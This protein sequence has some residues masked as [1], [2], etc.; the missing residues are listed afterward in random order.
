MEG[1]R[2]SWN[3]AK[4]RHSAFRTGVQSG[5]AQGLCLHLNPRTG[6]TYFEGGGQPEVREVLRQH[7]R[8]DDFLR[9]RG[10]LDYF[11]CLRRASWRKS[12]TWWRSRPIREWLRVYASTGDGIR[13]EHMQTHAPP[14]FPRCD[15][16]G[17]EVKVFRRAQRLLKEKRPGIICGIDSEEKQ[18]DGLERLL[19]F[20]YTWQP[21]GTNHLLARPQ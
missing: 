15:V 2:T 20:A 10:T 9:Y 12:S 5:P 14:N 6:K 21:C 16:Q 17:V 19:P 13:D 7:L 1:K 4:T 11:P 18:R 8:G 3:K